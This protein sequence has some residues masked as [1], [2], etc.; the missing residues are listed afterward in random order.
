MYKG[1]TELRESGTIRVS[2]GKAGYALIDP[3]KSLSG[4][5]ERGIPSLPDASY[6]NFIYVRYRMRGRGIG[7]RMLRSI[8]AE[9]PT[10]WGIAASEEGKN[11]MHRYPRLYRR[12]A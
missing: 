1:F 6:L 5:T 8:K 11:L 4:D 12:G 3:K 10:L 9:Y 2:F 7:E